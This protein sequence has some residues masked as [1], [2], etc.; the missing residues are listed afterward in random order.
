M[1]TEV[2]CM[3]HLSLVRPSGF[4][5]IELLIA[6]L[7][8]G[9]ILAM[10]F[11]AISRGHEIADLAEQEG[12]MS[13]NLEDILALFNTEIRTIGFPPESYFDSEY[14][15]YPATPRNLVSHGILPFG[16]HSLEFEGDINR[17]GKVDYVR[18]Y[19]TGSSAPYTLNRFAGELHADGSLPG[20]T[21]QKLSEQIEGLE[22]TCLDRWGRP[23]G[24]VGNVASIEIHLTLRSKN[25]DP[26]Q[27]IYRT[28]SELTRIHPLNL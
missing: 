9:T 14:L 27:K 11:S 17:N 13:A 10:V 4:S 26:N 19:L 15:Q 12:F 5:L 7:V 22:F 8:F 20:G 18:Y 16:L 6:L 2:S 25:R 24:S 21:A 1:Q 3:K 23:T 28:I